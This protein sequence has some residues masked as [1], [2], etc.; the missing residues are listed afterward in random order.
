MKKYSLKPLGDSC[1][2][3]ICK[4]AFLIGLLMTFSLTACS[5]DDDDTVT[6]I[7]P[8]KQNIICNAGDT[9][10]FTFTANTNWSLASS[11]I[12]C[13]F[14]T[15]E[16]EE[17]TLSGAAGTQTVTLMVTDDNQK[18]DN[19]SV[20]K[21]ELTMG[22]QTIVIGEITRSKVDYELT[23]YDAAG[24]PIDE[25]TGALVV[26]YKD[27]AKFSVKANF[28]FA[29]TN[30]PGWVEL[31]GGS[32]VG[33]VNQQVSG[34]LK[35]IENEIREKYPVVASNENVI[36]FSDEEG[37]VFRSVKVRYAGMP[38]GVLDLTLP[39]SNKFDW[40]VSLDGKT[41]TQGG[42]GVAGTGSSNTTFKNRF[43]FTVKTFNDE[44]VVVFVV[45]GF[46]NNNLYLMDQYDEW[47]SYEDDPK[48][49]NIKLKVNEFI[50]EPGGPTERVGY[51]LVLTKEEYETIGEDNLE[52]T[53][54]N[55][56]EIAYKYEQNNLVIQFTQKEVKNNGGD[57]SIT[58]QDGLSNADI[59]CT[60]Y[61]G[62]DATYFKSEYGVTGIYE[63]KQP[64]EKTT[65][66]KMPFSYTNVV[67]YYFDDEQ[68]AANVVEPYTE[69]D[70]S[71]YTEDANGRDV[72]LIITDESGNKVML[73]VRISN[74]GSGGG[75][76]S[77]FTITDMMLNPLSCIAYDG[78]LGG[79]EYFINAYNVNDLFQISNVPESIN[80]T[81][82][83]SNILS[84]E[85]YD[86]D[87][88][89]K[90][91]VNDDIVIED[92]WGAGNNHLNVWFG[93]SQITKS[94]FLVIT[95]EDGAKHMLFIFI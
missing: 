1:I 24:N 22:G 80:V 74:A 92:S 15:D 2:H 61:T 50:P 68:V 26:G 75:S 73:I 53:I 60:S 54:I 83:S 79:A 25:K 52:E 67:C 55:G 20:A 49:G 59:E 42:G 94:V 47:M 81:L 43:P 18:V 84:F 31:D 82:N 13:K 6:P 10:E 93:G 7:F 4:S 12:W 11:A 57:V 44:Y 89:N 34:G 45:K 56:E 27:F 33:A 30:L 3:I 19:I 63:I 77:V 58:A 51:V 69:K 76:D 88:E 87:T 32:M 8:E 91:E 65:I 70:I 21:L 37:R 64:S 36:T 23:I 41:F 48:D 66:A 46:A 14:K 62:T 16:M 72:F 71:I 90:I 86:L 5:D 35:I 38:A 95:G 85:C 78:S 9:R 39:S 40:T 28:R 17:F 29:A